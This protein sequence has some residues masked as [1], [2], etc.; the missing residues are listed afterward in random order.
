MWNFCITASICRNEKGYCCLRSAWYIK[1]NMLPRKQEGQ[2]GFFSDAGVIQ[3][4]DGVQ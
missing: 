1:T 2:K 3:Y 4:T